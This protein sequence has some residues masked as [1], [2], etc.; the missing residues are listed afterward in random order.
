MIV[1]Y[2]VYTCVVRSIVFIF[3]QK[4]VQIKELKKQTNKK[5]LYLKYLSMYYVQKT[6]HALKFLQFN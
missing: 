5:K 3:V 2:A 4:N 6:V 1:V